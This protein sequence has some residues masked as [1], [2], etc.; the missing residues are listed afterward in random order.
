MDEFRGKLAL[1]S[2]NGDTESFSSDSFESVGLGLGTDGELEVL[3]EGVFVSGTLLDIDSVWRLGDS[4]VLKGNIDSMLAV[5]GGIVIDGV[6]TIVVVCNVGGN[7]AVGTD[8]LDLE[9]ITSFAHVVAITIASFDEEFGGFGIVNILETRTPNKRVGGIGSRLDWDVVRGILNVIVVESFLCVEDDV[10][11]VVSR[12]NR[13][14]VDGVGTIV[15]VDDLGGNLGTLGIIDLGVDW[16][17]T[18]GKGLTFGVLGND[19]EGGGICGVT[20]LEARTINVEFRWIRIGVA[21]VDVD[22]PWAARDR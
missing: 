8:D 7:I 22:I 5:F 3:D 15:V 13:L 16:M 9:W 18:L 2:G 20:T 12:I 19:S 10:D 1:R 21:P 11:L 14:V 6:G 4:V 17:A